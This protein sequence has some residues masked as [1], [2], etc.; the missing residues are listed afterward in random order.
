M[1]SSLLAELK[2]I[3]TPTHTPSAPPPKNMHKNNTKS[4]PQAIKTSYE[5][6][7]IELPPGF[8]ATEPGVTTPPTLTE[9]DWS[10]T[11]LPENKGLYAVVLDGVLT[12][13]ECEEL[14]KLAEASVPL[15]K[16]VDVEGEGEG[17]DR[18][19][20]QSQSQN[21]ETETE[22][23]TEGKKT[24]WAPALVNVGLGYEV[25]TPSYRNSSRIIWDQQEV[26]DRLWER[27]CLAPGLRERLAVLDAG[28]ERDAKIITGMPLRKPEAEN[29]DGEQQPKEVERYANGKKK[30]KRTRLRETK[31]RDGRTGKWEFVRVNKRMRFLRYSPG[32]FFRAHCD[33]PYRELD[34]VNSD[35]INET[36]FTI[37]LYL[38]DCK[39]EA[40][41][42][43]KDETKL[44]GGATALLSGDEKRK[45]DVECKAGRVLIFQH[46]RVFHAGADVI[47]GVKYS[48]RTDI[49]YREI[50]EEKEE[51]MDEQKG[52]QGQQVVGDEEGRK[53]VDN[54][55]PLKEDG[56][57]K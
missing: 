12:R 5:S 17:V 18:T 30:G 49:M 20:R 21:K 13:E 36:L 8:L 57:G 16:W 42:G 45:Y 43:K 56:D 22:T 14:K 52:Q 25:H 24:P 41:P 33:S 35:R 39:S 4:H 19:Q 55:E 3:V 28:T 32:Q 37:H 54:G 40:P 51:E 11:E 50:L 23:G 47:K 29:E 7:P 1:M 44:E 2:S 26:V 31:W 10:Q 48:V 15:D 27:C 38:N 53:G 6:L 46:R 34:P 9:L